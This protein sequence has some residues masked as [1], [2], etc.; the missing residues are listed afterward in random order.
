MDCFTSCYLFPSGVGKPAMSCDYN[1]LILPSTSHAGDLWHAQLQ[2]WGPRRSTCSNC[3]GI[4]SPGGCH[5]S[6]CSRIHQSRC[7]RRST[8]LDLPRDP[9]LRR[10]T[11]LGLS[12]I[13]ISRRLSCLNLPEDLHP[14][15]G[16]PDYQVATVL[17]RINFK[18]T[19][20]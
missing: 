6:T 1:P 14:G 19:H 3:L 9:I 15:L 13:S 7:R 16:K 8:C 2:P 18:K 11:C 12:G 10:P 4:W 20:L 17:G 5:S